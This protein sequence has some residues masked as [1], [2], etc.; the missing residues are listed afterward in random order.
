[1]EQA[2]LE[3]LLKTY[4][5]PGIAMGVLVWLVRQVVVDAKADRS[6]CAEERR[7]FFEMLSVHA[8]RDTESLERITRALDKIVERL[9]RHPAG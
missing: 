1:M 8:A 3:A 7:T 9:D 2:A 6:A 4:G 5:L